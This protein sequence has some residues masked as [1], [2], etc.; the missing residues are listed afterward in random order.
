MFWTKGSNDALPFTEHFTGVKHVSI[1]SC[2][3]TTTAK[4][5]PPHFGSEKKRVRKVK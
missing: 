4:G 2:A 3:D 5:L 1:T